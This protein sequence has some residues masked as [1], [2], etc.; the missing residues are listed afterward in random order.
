MKQNEYVTIDDYPKVDEIVRSIF[1]TERLLPDY[2]FRKRYRFTLMADCEGMMGPGLTAILHDK[3]FCR[4]TD[5]ILMSVLDPDPV[6]YFHKRY[7]KINSLLFK[8]G[9]SEGE[10]GDLRCLDPGVPTGAIQFSSN[11]LV[12]IP[13]N[14]RWAIWGD[15][16]ERETAVI[17]FDD[18]AQ[19][20]FL[21][22]EDGYWIDAET[23]ITED[24]ASAPYRDHKAPE[25]FARALIENYGSRK[26]LEAKLAAA[27]MRLKPGI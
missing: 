17:G 22:N 6:A 19:A 16:R 9:I 21:L 27:D 20:D 15:R 18:P 14:G 24:F 10:Y 2:I 11:R 3:R 7:G 5:T 23:A 1:H 12:W 26:D 4:P 8:A 13:D 25:D